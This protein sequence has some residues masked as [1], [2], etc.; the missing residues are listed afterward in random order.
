MERIQHC[1]YTTPLLPLPSYFNKIDEWGKPM[2]AQIKCV[3][4]TEEFSEPTLKSDNQKIT[5]SPYFG[6]L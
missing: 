5:D 4:K 6:E 2:K 3:L 1:N